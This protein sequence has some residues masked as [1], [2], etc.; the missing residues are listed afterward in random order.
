MGGGEWGG[1]GGEWVGGGGWVGWGGAG[2]GNDP[3]LR[4]VH[5][6]YRMNMSIQIHIII[7]NTTQRIIIMLTILFNVLK[8]NYWQY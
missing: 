3:C 8:Y 2:R 5:K 7:S 4:V 6:S 1:G